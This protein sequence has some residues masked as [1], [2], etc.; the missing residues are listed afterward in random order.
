[1]LTAAALAPPLAR[2]QERLVALDAAVPAAPWVLY[3]L[4]TLTSRTFYEFQLAYT[5]AARPRL[6]LHVRPWL[7]GRL[8]PATPATAAALAQAIREPER[9][10]A[11]LATWETALARADTAARAAAREPAYARAQQ[12][13]VPH[14]LARCC[15][16]T[17]APPLAALVCALAA[18]APVHLRPRTGGLRGLAV[19]H[20]GWVHLRRAD[21]PPTPVYH[22]WLAAYSDLNGWLHQPPLVWSWREYLAVWRGLHRKPVRP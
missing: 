15:P 22:A 20:G 3:S 18:R 8:L 10:H 13:A 12:C 1:M 16:R 2:L 4:H 11:D 17:G 19:L 6:A 21:T 5:P 14:I 9:L 7:T